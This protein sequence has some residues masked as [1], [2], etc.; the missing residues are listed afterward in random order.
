MSQNLRQYH[1]MFEK[2]KVGQWGRKGHYWRGWLWGFS[3]EMTFEQGPE[4]GE[5]RSPR[6]QK[7]R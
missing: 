7:K 5:G 4:G 2:S 3:E 1:H 6:G